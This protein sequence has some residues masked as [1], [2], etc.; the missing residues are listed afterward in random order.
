MRPIV[1]SGPCVRDGELVRSVVEGDKVF[2]ESW[3][4]GAW[5][6]GR[7]AGDALTDPPAS[8]ETL[9]TFGLGPDGETPLAATSLGG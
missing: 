9:A 2:R 4:G 5:I 7:D 8:A 6:R 1:K 3:S